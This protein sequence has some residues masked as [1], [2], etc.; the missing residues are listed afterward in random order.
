MG[1]MLDGKGNRAT[2][3]PAAAQL[4]TPDWGSLFGQNL[5]SGGEPG[6]HNKVEDGDK[7]SM[8]NFL[9]GFER[10][11]D[12]PFSSRETKLLLSPVRLASSLCDSSP[13]KRIPIMRFPTAMPAPVLVADS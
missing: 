1:V 13:A 7:Q 2:L 8:G 10:S 6:D 9:Q 4:P 5:L 12:I 11:C 3:P